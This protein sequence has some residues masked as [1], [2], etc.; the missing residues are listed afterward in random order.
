VILN[1]YPNF[2]QPSLQAGQRPIGYLLGKVG[3][4]QED[5]EIVGQCMKLKFDFVLRYAIARQSCP[6]DRLSRN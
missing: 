6:A 3:A 5:T 1:P 2:D 4:L